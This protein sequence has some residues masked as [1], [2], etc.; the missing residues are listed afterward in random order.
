MDSINEISRIVLDS[1]ISWTH[2]R[3]SHTQKKGFGPKNNVSI[4]WY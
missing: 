4:Q 2:A 3:I 1:W